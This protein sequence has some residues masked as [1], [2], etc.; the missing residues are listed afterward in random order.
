VEHAQ[1]KV[2]PQGKC[3]HGSTNGRVLVGELLVG[4]THRRV[5]LR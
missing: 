3:I 1:D 4:F 2:G 5:M